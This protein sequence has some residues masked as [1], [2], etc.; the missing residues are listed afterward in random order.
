[1]SNISVIIPSIKQKVLT[2][3]SVPRDVS[4]RVVREGTLNE[5]RNLGVKRAEHK[6]ILILDDDISFTE[7][8]FW[9]LTDRIERG[10]LIGYP[11]WDYGL[12]AGRVMAFHHRDWKR[13]GG[14]DESLKSHMGDTEFALNFVQDGNDVEQ[15][16]PD[17]IEHASHERSVTTWDRVWRTVYLAAKYPRSAPKLLNRTFMQASD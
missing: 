2:L 3:D 14:F 1:M 8:F 9:E 12:V 10:K 17:K 7:T 16:D 6:R 5:A 11:D 15:I 13:F 4:A